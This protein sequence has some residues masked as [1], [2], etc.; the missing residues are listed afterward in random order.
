MWEKLGA[1]G[2]ATSGPKG[3]SASNNSE[4]SDSI[5]T[6]EKTISVTLPRTHRQS[7]AKGVVHYDH[8]HWKKSYWSLDITHVPR[9]QK[10]YYVLRQWKHL[11]VKKLIGH[12]V[13][14]TG[15]MNFCV[16]TEIFWL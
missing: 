2:G 11:W 9:G 16:I 6:W 15:K 14:M 10:W 8:D 3:I 1:V 12:S 4:I 5:E 7:T 13:H